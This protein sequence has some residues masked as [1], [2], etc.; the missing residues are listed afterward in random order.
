MKQTIEVIQAKAFH[1]KKHAKYLLVIPR[2]ANSQELNKAMTACFGSHVFF[3][4]EAKDVNA[5]KIAEIMKE[6]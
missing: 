4:L 6:S 3:I 2:I 5:V 1:I